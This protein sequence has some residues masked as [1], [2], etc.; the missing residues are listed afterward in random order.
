VPNSSELARDTKRLHDRLAAK[1]SELSDYLDTLKKE[2][3]MYESSSEPT[4][5][6]GTRNVPRTEA[7]RRSNLL[8]AKVNADFELVQRQSTE[9]SERMVTSELTLS[10]ESRDA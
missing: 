4:V 6:F 10:D 7:I 9:L 8:I 2:L 1:G 5:V 3:A